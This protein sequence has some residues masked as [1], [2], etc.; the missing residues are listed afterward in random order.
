MGTWV[1]SS[2]DIADHPKTLRLAELL[3]MDIQKTVGAIH[4]LWHFA[5]K[6]AWRDGDMEKFGEIAVARG[7]RWE[8]DP[9]KFIEALRQSGFLEGLKIH[10]WL[11]CAGKIVNS[12][13]YNEFRRKTP[14]NGDKRRKTPSNGD[15][16]SLPTQPTQP[17][18]REERRQKLPR[19]NVRGSVLSVT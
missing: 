6:F 10:D 9:H 8:G 17:T 7:S 16:T 2:I 4:L 11:D 19:K 18:V 15:N 13:I 3:G 14:S 5:M 1:E 12:R